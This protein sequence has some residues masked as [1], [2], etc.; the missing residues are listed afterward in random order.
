MEFEDLFKPPT[1]PTAI[2]INSEPA[3]VLTYIKHHGYLLADIDFLDD[4]LCQHTPSH[5]DEWE[6]D[7]DAIGEIE[8]FRNL[9]EGKQDAE[10]GRWLAAVNDPTHPEFKKEWEELKNSTIQ[11]EIKND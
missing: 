2:N 4:Y 9:A 5:P 6:T 10:E 11:K 7:E 1:I 8:F 3:E